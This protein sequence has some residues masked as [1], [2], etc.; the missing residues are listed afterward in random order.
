[1][2]KSKLRRPHQRL[3]QL[4]F[5]ASASSAATIISIGDTSLSL[6]NFQ[7][8]TQLSVPLGCLLAYNNPI[9][10]CTANDFKEGSTCSNSCRRGLSR[11]QTN[12]QDACEAV[13]VQTNTLLGQ[14]LAGNLINLLCPSTAQPTSAAPPVQPSSTSIAQHSS[15]AVI[16][17]PPPPPPPATT[18]ARPIPPPATTS[19]VIPPSSPPPANP[20]RSTAGPPVSQLP[21]PPPPLPAPP[22]TVVTSAA[23]SDAAPQST[24]AET[25]KPEVNPLDALLMSGDSTESFK[26]SRGVVYVLCLLWASILAFTA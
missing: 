6:S 21:P 18:T 8:I 24:S 10:G 16:P 2:A 7:L 20:P 13:Q 1:M 12:L 23:T 26:A 11:M 22:T 9:A 25:K 5:L 17:P 3:V 19:A 4:L 14:A 15:T